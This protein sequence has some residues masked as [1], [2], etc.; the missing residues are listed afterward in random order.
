MSVLSGK[1]GS[2]WIAGQRVAMVLWWELTK[3]A[4]SKAYVA[5]DT[6]GWRRRVAGVKD[7][8]GRLELKFP[9]ASS[10]PLEEGQQV[11]LQLHLDSSGQNYYEL[12]AL[13]E[14]ISSRVDIATGEAIGWV[15][16]FVGTGPL[17]G[18]G[19]LEYNPN[20]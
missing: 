8:A 18:Y 2:V 10:P 13:I 9:A 11:M 16:D 3:R 4:S 12:P 6:G 7:S 19:I 14:R 20:S 15:V 1:D 5:N 17:R